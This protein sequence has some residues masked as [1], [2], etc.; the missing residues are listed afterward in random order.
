MF[1]LFPKFGARTRTQDLWPFLI[2]ETGLKFLIW[3]QGKIY[4]GNRASPVNRAHMKRPLDTVLSEYPDKSHNFRNFIFMTSHLSTLFSEP[5]SFIRQEVRRNVDAGLFRPPHFENEFWSQVLGVERINRNI[6][7][8]V[9]V[10]MTSL[11]F[12]YPYV[13]ILLLS[14]YLVFGLQFSQ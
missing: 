3:T 11:S 4:P 14:R 2:S 5:L 13:L 7:F 12:L 8:P 10:F 6:K 1:A 9:M